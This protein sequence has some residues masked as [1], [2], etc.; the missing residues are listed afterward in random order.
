MVFIGDVHLSPSAPA[1]T[2]LFLRFLDVAAARAQAIVILGDLFDYWVGARQATLPE[3]RDVLHA[4]QQTAARGCKLFFIAGNRDFH[5]N[6]RLTRELGIEV[7]PDPRVVQLD[8]RRVH[9]THGDLLCE[10]D[11]AY[12]RLRKLL[13]NPLVMAVTRLL[14]LSVALRMAQGLRRKSKA[15]IATK[16]MAEMDLTP[17][18]VTR[19]FEGGADV[20][21]CGHVHKPRHEKQEVA[22]RRCE[23]LVVSD[24]QE[25]ARYVQYENGTFTLATWS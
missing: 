12:Q 20:L 1:R 4:L 15:E 14:P 19:V 24:W 2:K 17:G 8:N 11:Y 25:S 22:G 16:T 5:F 10:G 18:A 9:L 7:M 3:Y 13:R 23:L 6:G 21:I